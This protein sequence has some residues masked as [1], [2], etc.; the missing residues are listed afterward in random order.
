MN[1][2]KIGPKTN[3]EI[4][5][6]L[7]IGELA[8]VNQSKEE[9]EALTSPNQPEQ[10]LYGA[11]PY[12]DR[13]AGI[14]SR[15]PGELEYFDVDPSVQSMQREV[16]RGAES[17]LLFEMKAGYPL[18]RMSE[19]ILANYPEREGKGQILGL[20][21]LAGA[22]KSTALQALQES[23]GREA[24]VIDSDRT[25]FNLLA[26]MVLEAEKTGGV[27][28]QD[29]KDR[30]IIHNRISFPL[31]FLI[32]HVSKVLKERG[33][34][35]VRAATLPYRKADTNF[36][37]EHPD[38]IDPLELANGDDEDIARAAHVLFQRTS[39]R[40]E[41]R[42]N[43]DWENA[44]LVTKFEDMSDV[45]VQVPEVVHARNIGAIAREIQQG[46]PYVLKNP[47]VSSV[48]EAREGLKNQFQTYE[49]H[50]TA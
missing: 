16:T 3:D 17:A 12:F 15:L 34:T 40:V 9:L 31:F 33:Y 23:L 49:R 14:L 24:V 18:S 19:E 43:Y 30:G 35:V 39:Q 37:I 32:D 5:F 11:L 41:G 45:T 26:K 20:F 4:V 46:N 42:D 10:P 6:N 22:G 27:S 47:K 8:L 50:Q 2:E 44:K 25:R 48:E 28:T 29:V 1:N 36:Y 21:G 38:G 13:R 7:R